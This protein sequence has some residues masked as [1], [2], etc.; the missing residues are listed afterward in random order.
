MSDRCACTPYSQDAGG[1][2][3]ELLAEPTETCPVHGDPDAILASGS[4]TDRRGT[5]WG[6]MRGIDRW[7]DRE[8][9]TDLTPAQM[10]LKI[11][12]EQ[13]RN[14]CE[15]LLDCDDHPVPRVYRARPFWIAG[16]SEGAAGHRT[17]AE[18]IAAAH[19]MTGESDE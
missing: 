9:T 8:V 16:D 19:Q 15:G 10:R 2:Y 13:H 6:Y 1:G 11:V 14:R 12:R 4:Y 5:W 18:A 7:V 3:F 17:L